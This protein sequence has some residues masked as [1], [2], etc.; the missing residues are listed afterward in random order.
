MPT[1]TP[2]GKLKTTITSLEIIDAIR[3][4]DGA[5]LTE[6]VNE[7][8][9]PKSTVHKHLMT[10]LD[11]GFLVRE[12][13]TYHLG[14]K[15]LN[16]G[17]HARTR[18][19]GYRLAEDMV[20]QLT[21]LTD[22]EADFVVEDH[23]RITTISESYHKWVKYQPPQ[24]SESNRYRAR[25]GTFYY[26]HATASGKA[27]LAERSRDYVEDVIE[28]WG[29]PAKTENTITAESELFTELE[30]VRERGY[31]CDQEEFTDGL[32]SVGKVVTDTD[33]SILGALSVSGPTYRMTGDVLETEI[34]DALRTVT[35]DFES[36]L[37]EIQ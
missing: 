36:E 33:G 15:F 9:L 35:D 16:L 11:N 10:L 27:I 2:N 21:N 12:E 14:L 24:Q 5:R 20:R 3:D 31:A 26:M 37:E 1:D 18:K 32:R 28:Q 19:A 7:L 22:E 17:E 23:M 8:S 6:I 25:T 4:M 29:L 30:R 13:N 34:P